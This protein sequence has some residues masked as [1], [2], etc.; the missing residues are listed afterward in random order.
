[1]YSS[2]AGIIPLSLKYAYCKPKMIWPVEKKP[3]AETQPRDFLVCYSCRRY[4]ITYEPSRLRFQGFIWSDPSEILDEFNATIPKWID[5]GKLRWKE[6][7]LEGLENA[8]KAFVGLFRG[9]RIGRS[10]VIIL[11]A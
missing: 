6:N 4:C 2:K 11:S 3:T 8:P 9:E 1:M 7:I 5:E 10:L